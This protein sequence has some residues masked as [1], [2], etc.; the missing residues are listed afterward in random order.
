MISKGY[1]FGN[2]FLVGQVNAAPTGAT[3]KAITATAMHR[4]KRL[5]LTVLTI[6]PDTVECEEHRNMESSVLN[7]LKTDVMG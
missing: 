1:P 2:G 3:T 7:Y 5:F 6:L 4:A